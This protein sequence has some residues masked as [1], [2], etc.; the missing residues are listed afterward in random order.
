MT[1]VRFQVD[2]SVVGSINDDLNTINGTRRDLSANDIGREAVAVYK[3]V[4]EQTRAGRAVVAADKELSQLVQI[5][6]PN[7]PARNPTR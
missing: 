2:P 6:T 5:A 3:W 4:V 1:E 7:L